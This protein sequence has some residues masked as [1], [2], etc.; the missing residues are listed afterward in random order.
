MTSAEF[1]PQSQVAIFRIGQVSYT[2]TVQEYK[3]I[4]S[5]LLEVFGDIAQ[6]VNALLYFISFLLHLVQV[7]QFRY[8][9]LQ[10]VFHIL[11][12][13]DQYYFCYVLKWYGA[14]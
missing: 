5:V 6:L 3:I 10:E 11:W 4:I 14:L 9:G 12:L 7:K 13:Y 1:C 8:I 2:D